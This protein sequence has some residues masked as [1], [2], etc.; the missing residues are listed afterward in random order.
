MTN[1]S[2]ADIKVN[3]GQQAPTHIPYGQMNIASIQAGH[4]HANLGAYDV[5]SLIAYDASGFHFLFGGAVGVGTYPL[6]ISL[7]K[8]DGKTYLLVED[9]ITFFDHVRDAGIEI[10]SNTS[11]RIDES[12]E[13]DFTQSV[14]RLTESA[15]RLQAKRLGEKTEIVSSA[16]L[17]HRTDHNTLSGDKLEIANFHIGAVRKT[18]LGNIGLAIGNQHIEQQGLVFNGFNRR[19]ISTHMES[20]DGLYRV[21]TFLINSDPGVSSK[22]NVILASDTNKQSAGAIL[23]FEVF[24]THPGRLRISSGYIDGKSELSGIGFGFSN[25]FFLDDPTPIVYGGKTWHVSANSTWL[26]QSL[27]LQAEHA[28]SNFDSDG[29]D[30]GEEAKK[31]KASVYS[32]AISSRG[33]LANLLKPLRVNNW[34]LSWRQQTVG[35]D[36]FS[37]A[38]LGLPGDLSTNQAALQ[39]GWNRVQLSTEYTRVKNNID[40][41]DNVPT[42]TTNQTQLSAN[43]SPFATNEQSLWQALGRPSLSFRLSK[44]QREQT[45]DHALLVGYDLD[46]DT[47]EYQLS[48]SFQREKLN[49]SIQHNLTRYTNHAI[50]LES[51]GL[52]IFEP[53]PD[54]K[55]RFTALSAHFNPTQNISLSPSLQR[56]DYDESQSSN[57][58]EAF[59]AGLNANIRM[60]RDKLNVTIN[61]NQAEQNSI[62]SSTLPR[63][64]YQNQQAS[65]IVNWQAIT[66]KGLNPGLKFSLRHTWSQQKVSL[67]QTQD[68][69]QITLGME[70]YWTQGTLQ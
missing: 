55:N 12:E 31:D 1:F 43:Y 60:F 17:Q 54:T 30:I 58:Q 37:L 20:N 42:Q 10:I 5:T 25:D 35:E 6:R 33:N 29:F 44:S 22:E 51:D 4:L 3:V 15:L 36:F 23:D 41:R 39:L 59:N 14:R 9:S 62:F 49:W 40:N 68:N 19:G 69:Y 66:P 64:K 8:P 24:R 27:I 38:N 13:E 61:Y 57:E 16:D 65:A 21:K 70:L 46:D 45:L 28:Q 34:L 18:S 11:Y 48:A 63:Q 50:A 2:S 53:G 56:S 26:N 7:T 32:A 67:Q 47:N 52:T